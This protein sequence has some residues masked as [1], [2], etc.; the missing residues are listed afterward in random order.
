MRRLFS[1]YEKQI[2]YVAIGVWNTLFWYA[3]FMA[4]YHVLTPYG[5]HY[6]VILVIS[7][8]LSVTNA[9]L[10]NKIFVFKTK[11]NYGREYIR[12]ASYHVISFAINL[13]L[14]P[15]FV[16]VMGYDP[17]LAQGGI[18]VASIVLSFFWHSYI[19]F[20]GKTAKS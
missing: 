17:V 10:A 5:V 3:V 4:L 16:E 11:G 6:T 13:L 19:T 14:L 9:Y 18:I 20:S 8:V 7:Q 12:F 1:K 2:K 15:F